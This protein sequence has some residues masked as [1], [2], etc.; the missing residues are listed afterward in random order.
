MIYGTNDLSIYERFASEWWEPQ[1]PRFRSLQ[2]VTEFRLQVIDNWFGSVKGATVVDLGCG[3]GLLSVPMLER[4]ANVIG[5]D[6]SS[7]SLETAK[8]MSNGKGKYLQ[9]DIRKV[10]LPNGCADFVL[11]ADVLDHIQDYFKALAEARRILKPGGLLYVNTINRTFRSWFFALLLGEGTG[12]IPRGTH[13]FRLFIRPHE[14]A[15]AAKL[16]RFSLV[17][18]QGEA[19]SISSTVRDWAITF[20]ASNSKAVAYSALFKAR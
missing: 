2:K 17:E 19:P 15:K 18:M 16:Q 6:L 9:G 11:L 13:D 20:R 5:V 7:G 4:G 3:G 1:S 8:R 10:E 12:L 14:L